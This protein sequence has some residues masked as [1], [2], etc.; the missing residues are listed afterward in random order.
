MSTNKLNK[1]IMKNARNRE[2]L[3]A[4]A[5]EKAINEEV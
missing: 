1:T 2:L 4:E 5:Q 3:Y